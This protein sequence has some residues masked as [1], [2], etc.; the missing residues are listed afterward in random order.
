MISLRKYVLSYIYKIKHRPKIDT[1]FWNDIF[2]I[3]LEEDLHVWYSIDFFK[4]FDWYVASYDWNLYSF[5]LGWY[6]VI[7]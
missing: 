6:F 3:D 4:W 1:D 7:W 2:L 5:W